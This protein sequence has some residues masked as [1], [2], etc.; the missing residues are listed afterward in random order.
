MRQDDDERRRIAFVQLRRMGSDSATWWA[1]RVRAAWR[2]VEAQH[3]TWWAQW[4]RTAWCSAEAQQR[5]HGA[6]A[7]HGG[8]GRIGA[9]RNGGVRCNSGLMARD[10]AS[11]MVAHGTTEVQ[12]TVA[13]PLAW[14]GGSAVGATMHLAHM[15]ATVAVHLAY[16]T[17][18]M[19]QLKP[20]E[21][22][23]VASWMSNGVL[24][25]HHEEC[26]D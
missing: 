19:L 11:G 12:H 10:V 25:H 14:Y 7:Q 8:L 1:Q 13:R 26:G 2:S 15:T 6:E 9:W 20:C 22:P 3:A 16:A 24:P 5:R 17:T 4:V 21:A 23:G 18:T